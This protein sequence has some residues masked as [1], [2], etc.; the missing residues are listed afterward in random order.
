MH[1]DPIP[2]AS[3][4]DNISSDIVHL[5]YLLMRL[6]IDGA[7]PGKQCTVNQVMDRLEASVSDLVSRF[8]SIDWDSTFGHR[9]IYYALSGGRHLRDQIVAI[10]GKVPADRMGTMIEHVDELYNL[11]IPV[12]RMR[13]ALAPITKAYTY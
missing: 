2:F 3:L 13:K 6:K 1:M 10:L 11:Y 8:E 12:M 9:E 4:L 5:C 7:Q